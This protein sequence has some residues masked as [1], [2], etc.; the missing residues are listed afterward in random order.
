MK[1]GFKIVFI[2]KKKN[3]NINEGIKTIKD[4]KT[5]EEL[6]YL[7]TRYIEKDLFPKE[8]ITFVQL[9]DKAYSFDLN[10]KINETVIEKLNIIIKKSVID[11]N[12]IDDKH[13]QYRC[14]FQTNPNTIDVFLYFKTNFSDFI[15]QLKNIIITKIIDLNFQQLIKD[16]PVIK[17]TLPVNYNYNKFNV[18]AANTV[19]LIECVLYALKRTTLNSIDSQII[20]YLNDEIYGE[21]HRIFPISASR[22]RDIFMRLQNETKFYK[23]L[24]VYPNNALKRLSE[25]TDINIQ[26]AIIQVF[27]NVYVN[28]DNSSYDNMIKWLQTKIERNVG[29]IEEHIR[30][31]L[32]I[33]N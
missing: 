9:P 7:I 20:L 26:N 29:R 17:D 4:I 13:F 18:W 15:K 28:I 21:K 24:Y 5:Y 8:K 31:Q 32:K 12:I 25:I 33:K 3:R 19:E 23:I 2:R 11:N 22:I 30:R 10:L 1:K 16:K 14:I 27:S 6:I